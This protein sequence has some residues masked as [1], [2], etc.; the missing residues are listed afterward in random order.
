MPYILEEAELTEHADEPETPEPQP[1]I[2]EQTSTSVAF[3]ATAEPETAE[4]ETR[5]EEQTALVPTEPEVVDGEVVE[6]E[7]K[8]RPEAPTPPK[9]K[10]YWLLIPF[11]IVLCLLYLAVSVLLPLLTPSAT[12]TIIP[13]ERTITTTTAIQVHGR[14]LPAFTLS[15]S[16]TAPATGKRHQDATY[17]QGEITFY[18]GQ[19]SE[20]TIA[21][22]TILTGADGVQVITDQL[23][24]IPAAN[25]PSIGQG[26]V[27]AHALDTGLQ[28]NIQ[29]YD[30]NQACCVTAVKAVNTTAFT[31][32][33]S[34]RDDVVV[35]REDIS[36]AVTSLLL[37]LRQSEHAALLAQLPPG[38][39]LITPSCPP[40]VSSD[41][42]PGD[43]AR[44]ASVTVSLTCTGIAYDAHS[45]YAEALQLL[46]SQATTALGANYSPI[47][48]IQVA[49]T[50]ATIT[51]QAHGTVILTVNIEATF[52]YQI[53]PGEQ[54]QI[55]NLIAGKT[56]QQ[57]LALLSKAPGIAGAVITTSGNTATLPD[58]P[59]KVTIVIAERL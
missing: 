2:A 36:N 55:V 24:V 27:R 37:T 31:G 59:G 58:N 44:E 23:A 6:L 43:E 48:G 34:A 40:H 56:T 49:I 9:Q 33:Q 15:Q 18:N 50:H 1:E 28:G 11:A 53:S 54:Q 51:N 47:G 8:A 41:H 25:L 35:T 45:V 10:P 30:I 13:V 46:P 20:V 32:G 42:K 5:R 39:D 29:A 7:P 17:A 21:A 12:V 22:G 4:P 19:L 14:L 52:V 26:T 38:S 57:A 16:Q 3:D